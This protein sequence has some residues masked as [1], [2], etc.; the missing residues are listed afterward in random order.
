MSSWPSAFFSLWRLM[1]RSVAVVPGLA[2]MRTNE[3]QPFTQ[4]RARLSSGTAPSHDT[5]LPNRTTVETSPRHVALSQHGRNTTPQPAALTGPSTVAQHSSCKQANLHAQDG[6]GQA[7]AADHQGSHPKGAQ[8]GTSCL[9]SY[10]PLIPQRSVCLRR[11]RR[12]TAQTELHA[13][14]PNALS[15]VTTAPRRNR[16]CTLNEP[17]PV[18]RRYVRGL[19]LLV[20]HYL[21]LLFSVRF[22]HSQHT[23]RGTP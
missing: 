10:I 22:V 3:A 23:R 18:G 14:S 13:L 20:A 7:Q 6:E 17:F 4:H 19:R 9:S 8:E 2:C 16:L 1:S 15:N 11:N 5:S 21:Y 12:R